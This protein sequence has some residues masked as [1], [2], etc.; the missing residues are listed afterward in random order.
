MQD[1]RKKPLGPFPASCSPN[2]LAGRPNAFPLHDVRHI[3]LPYAPKR[4]R[5]PETGFRREERAISRQME[6]PK[7]G[8]S[9][10]GRVYSAPPTQIIAWWSQTGSNRRPHACKARALP[11]E[12]WPLLAIGRS[13]SRQLGVAS[14]LLKTLAGFET[15]A[16]TPNSLGK[17]RFPQTVR[18]ASRERGA[19]LMRGTQAGGLPARWW[20]WEDSNLR[21]HAYQARAL[22]N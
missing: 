21:P 9:K 8:A 16:P 20:A 18:F 22:T 15:P 13:S 7:S 3:L 10:A 19:E 14:L 2:P 1:K 17:V 6:P 5:G 12:L 11:T 4:A